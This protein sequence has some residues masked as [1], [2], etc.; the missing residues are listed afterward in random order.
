[1]DDETP[2][3]L[4]ERTVSVLIATRN[5][6]SVLK[7]TLEDLVAQDYP[8]HSF[9]TVVIDDDSDDETALVVK[10]AA[11]RHSDHRIHY[12]HQLRKGPSSARNLGIS[13]SGGELII[14][15]DD[16]VRIPR[17]W[18]DR[19]VA[20]SL[21]HPASEC[22]AGR[23]A[24][25]LE[26]SG[27]R[28]CGREPLGESEFDQGDK[29]EPARLDQV[30]AANM[31]IRRSATERVGPFLPDLPVYGEETEW[32]HRLTKH[33]GQVT[34]V[35]DVFL[36]HRRSADQLDLRTM[37]AARYRRG[38]SWPRIA[39]RIPRRVSFA[40]AATR[41]L[42]ALLHLVGKRCWIGALDAAY[43]LGWAREAATMSLKG[44]SDFVR[45]LPGNTLSRLRYRLS[46][47]K[48]KHRGS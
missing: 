39:P 12:L 22:L 40:E 21:R 41:I 13:S 8:A 46:R 30:A 48:G 35:S 6:S 10:D 31:L 34:Y 38:R 32:V 3:G 24:V 42:P 2:D 43:W 7:D 19:F 18:L 17:E 47:A 15:V 36:W 27:P 16:D 28:T 20:A 29:D 26:V 45:W 44:D 1:M 5:R 33:G 37:L 14:L 4:Q 11:R 25:Y 9:E 23:I